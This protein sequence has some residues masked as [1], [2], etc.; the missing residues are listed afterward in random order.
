MTRSVSSSHA[1][2]GSLVDQKTS[3]NAVADWVGLGFALSKTRSFLGLGTSL[4]IGKSFPKSLP[5]VGFGNIIIA[6]Q[7][8]PN[9]VSSFTISRNSN[10]KVRRN[11]FFILRQIKNNSFCFAIRCLRCMPCRQSFA[12]NKTNL[13]FHWKGILRLLQ[14]FE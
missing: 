6:H 5:R 3:R 1:N 4:G 9:I 2:F 12:Y 7:F 8:K 14:L 13:L 10:T 11:Y